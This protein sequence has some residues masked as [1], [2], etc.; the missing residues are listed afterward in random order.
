MNDKTITVVVAEPQKPAEVRQIANTLEAL[1]EIVGGYIE[2]LPRA[3]EI[4]GCVVIANEDGHPLGLEPNRRWPDGSVLRGTIV[5]VGR[6][7]KADHASLSREEAAGIA[8]RL[9][10]DRV[11]R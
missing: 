6:G 10:Q 3:L 7:E 2:E 11:E 9:R 1:Q 8:L 5:V 4:A